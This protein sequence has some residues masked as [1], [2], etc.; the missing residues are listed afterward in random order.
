M[1][2]RRGADEPGWDGLTDKDRENIAALARKAAKETI[3]SNDGLKWN[4]K[5]NRCQYDF[6]QDV[7]E[8]HDD[9]EAC[10]KEEFAKAGEEIPESVQTLLERGKTKLMERN[11][12]L[13]RADDASWDAVALFHRDPLC[14]TA[15][16]EKRWKLAKAEVKEREKAKNSLARGRGRGRGFDK[17]RG[18]G[19]GYGSAGLLYDNGNGGAF[20]PRGRDWSDSWRRSV[21][22]EYASVHSPVAGVSSTV[23]AEACLSQE[24]AAG[25]ANTDTRLRAATSSWRSPT[26]PG[27]KKKIKCDSLTANVHE[28][29][30]SACIK[31]GVPNKDLKDAEKLAFYEKTA[32]D[33]GVLSQDEIVIF[34]DDEK[35]DLKVKDTLR[36]HIA[37]WEASGATKFALSVIR[38]GYIPSFSK[39]P[40]EYEEPNNAS[41]KT[42]RLWANKAVEKLHSA[43][44]VKKVERKDLRC[45]NPL[46][47]ASNAVGKLRLC[48]DLSRHLNEVTR[49]PKFK[50]ESTRDALEVVQRGDWAFSFDLK[51]AYHQIPIHDSYHKYLGF[52]VLKENGETEHFCYVVMP[53]GWNDACRVLTK[54]LK[55]PMERW[56]KMGIRVFIHVDDGFGVCSS[57]VEC[58][59]ASERIRSDLISYGLLISE[60]KCSWGA[61]QSLLWTG[62]VWDFREF[63]LW[64]S[65]EKLVRAETEIRLLLEAGHVV[66]PAKQVARVVGLLGSFALAMGAIVRFRT[67]SLLTMLA[68]E[69]DRYGWN[70]GIRLGELELDEL[71]FWDQNLRGLNGFRMRREDKVLVVRSREMYSDASDFQM[72][73]A[74]FSGTRR[75]QGTEYQAYFEED[76]R[77]ASSTF[78]ELRAIEEGLRVRGQELR[79][80][81]VRWGC[82]NW[83]AG[84]IVKVG[85]M[86]PDC[87]QVALRIAELSKKFEIELEPFWLSREESQV[88]EVDSLSKEV[89]TGDY[90]LSTR[91]FEM[92]EQSFGPFSVDMFASSFSF[93]FSPF[94]ARVACSQ[95]AAV[96]AFTLDW[97][98]AGYMFLH[99]PV[100]LIVRVLRYAKAC[101]AAGL[102]V[103]PHWPGSIFMTELRAAEIEGKIFMVKEFQPELVSP[104]W[105]KSK[106]FHGPARF[107]F[108]VY[109]INFS[110]P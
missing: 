80:S 22:S 95:A 72:A 84:M 46:S 73:G 89:D 104:E 3:R 70:T 51:S 64:I 28:S 36:S 58:L 50:I 76:E 21:R 61:R 31:G 20:V 1:F 102:L 23:E 57:K 90:K 8:I 75:E 82:D 87:H 55:S 48:I 62:F 99:P 44:L 37:F 53:F 78:R 81:L 45:C 105:I 39:A 19:F 68:R 24:T 12:D 56:R 63:K 66:L 25:A 40:E 79:G 11:K 108:F 69:T 49:A 34:E 54:V 59:A 35:I 109:H 85:S 92:L 103:V 43:G 86:K 74:E 91:D 27:N 77:S 42:H 67:R 60:S 30:D 41:Y 107:D 71:K 5:G 106:T 26:S 94:V 2:P 65:E 17:L 4:N 9:L 110:A 97:G 7:A 33:V 18:R 10:L 93:Q 15:D 16:E 29:S 101:K 32:L 47:V 98:E 6:N 13:Q 52:K 38:E 14:S 96:D 83:S 100:G 88:V